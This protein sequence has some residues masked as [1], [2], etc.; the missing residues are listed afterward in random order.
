MLA[1]SQPTPRCSSSQDDQALSAPGPACRPRD[2]A[3]GQRLRSCLHHLD[4]ARPGG[5]AGRAEDP[6]PG[7]LLRAEGDY[8]DLRRKANHRQQRQG[9]RPGRTPPQPPPP[10][11]PPP[12]PPPPPA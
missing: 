6:D 9:D 10:P 2:R 5:P 11:A 7:R 12:P 1:T 8:R 4:D 3:G